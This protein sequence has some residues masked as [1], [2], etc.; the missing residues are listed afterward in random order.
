MNHALM[1]SLYLG[2]LQDPVLVND[3]VATRFAKAWSIGLEQHKVVNCLEFV[4]IMQVS[5]HTF[6]LETFK[7]SNM[8]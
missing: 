6:A 8:R 5:F 4:I 7:M 3:K 1:P 2:Q